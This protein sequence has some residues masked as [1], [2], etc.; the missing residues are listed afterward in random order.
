MIGSRR[1]G[2]RGLD[3]LPFETGPPNSE[4]TAFAAC[5]NGGVD[6]LVTLWKTRNK[7]ARR[8]ALPVRSGGQARAQ[9]RD[10][11][12]DGKEDVVRD[13]DISDSYSRIG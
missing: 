5:P 11:D 3:E 7:T 10:K 12:R 2:C 6:D 9:L 13:T 8:A 1:E 4:A